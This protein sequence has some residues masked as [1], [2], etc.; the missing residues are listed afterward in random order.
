MLC[1]HFI[2]KVFLI[3]QRKEKI[4]GNSP[5]KDVISILPSIINVEKCYIDLGYLSSRS[6]IAVKKEVSV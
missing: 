2:P 3:F 6:K 4:L 5:Y 1:F